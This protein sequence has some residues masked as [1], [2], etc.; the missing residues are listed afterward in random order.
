M[1]FGGE[2]QDAEKEMEAVLKMT[3]SVSKIKGIGAKKQEKL[4]S[5]GILSVEDLLNHFP[6]K[7][8]DRRKVIPSSQLSEGQSREQMAEGVLIRKNIRPYGNGRT[9]LSATFAD[10]FGEFRGVFFNMPFLSKNLICGEKYVV[11]GKVQFQKNIPVFQVPEICLPGSAKDVRGIVPVYRCTAG[12]G[13]GDFGKWI[14]YALSNVEF[15][16]E[17]IPEEAVQNR[18]ICTEAF[19]YQNLHFPESGG[20]YRVARTRYVYEMLFL[21]Q[22]IRQ[23]NRYQMAESAGDSSVQKVDCTPFFS[24]L[25]FDLTEGQTRA[26][27]DITEDLS[28]KQP[29]NRLV[30]GDVGCGKTVVAEAA[31]YQVTASGGQCV[32]MAPTE[33]LARQHFDKVSETFENLG[34]HCVLLI[35]ALNTSVK[36]TVLEEIASGR[37][38]VIIGTHAIIQDNVEFRNLELVITDEQHR[39]GVNQRRL[40]REKTSIPNVLVMSA[41]PIPRTLQATVYG[42]MDFSM[43]RTKPETRKRI[44]TR[45]VSKRQRPMAYAEIRKEVEKG[46]RA[47]IVVPSI[48]E[49]DGTVAS[50]EKVYE[51]AR[52]L[53]KGCRIAVLHGRMKPEEKET[54]MGDF[55]E[56]RMDVLVA[57]VVIEVGIDVPEATIMVIENADRF[58]L[59]QLHQLRGRVGRSN[60]QS[61]CWLVNYSQSENAAERLR[62]MQETDDGFI[63]SEE[64]YRLRGPGDIHGTMQHGNA[65]PLS[66]LT[67]YEKVLSCAAEDVRY[68]DPGNLGD[69]IRKKIRKYIVEDYENTI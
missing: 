29:M 63:I 10:E 34:V 11:F 58:G 32:F 39:F 37:A 48:E 33:I 50:V 67:R 62:I 69:E 2:A 51:D 38:L 31:M 9:L 36:R 47:Y 7:Y 17:W 13:S 25:P 57:T 21:H 23:W 30:Q 44:I 6:V 3:D 35:S 1:Q 59:A 16:E 19:K 60:R 24:S 66:D 45:T 41:T 20:A 53:L 61:Y 22:A 8:R 43:I 68:L 40:L 55:A 64:D 46:N 42:D 49:G 15:E 26:V 5:L 4:K 18:K 65:D 27:Q 56:G 12:I 14:R 52:K 54:I 28:K